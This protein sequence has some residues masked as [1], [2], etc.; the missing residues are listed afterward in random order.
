M[1]IC[2][3]VC[4]CE[5]VIS[6]VVIDKC[7]GTQPAVGYELFRDYKYQALYLFLANAWQFFTEDL[8]HPYV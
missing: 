8:E 3:C 7:Y 5:S 6:V 2:V 4:V 1:C